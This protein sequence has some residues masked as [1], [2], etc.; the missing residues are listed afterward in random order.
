VKL[1]VQIMGLV[2]LVAFTGLAAVALRQWRIRRD[3]AGAWAAAS[4]VAIGAVLVLGQILPDEP[5]TFVEHALQRL[6]IVVLLLF[7]WLV[8][9]Q[10]NLP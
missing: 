10:I 3:A 5:D 1:A 6:V 2:N 7:E 4:F 8:R 9:K